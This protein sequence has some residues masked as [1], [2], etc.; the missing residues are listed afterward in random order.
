M[1]GVIDKSLVLN[2]STVKS[3]IVYNTN[4]PEK[5]STVPDSNNIKDCKPELIEI[6]LD[7]PKEA[8]SRLKVQ[9][10]YKQDRIPV[11][12]ASHVNSLPR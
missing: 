10:V 2:P 3:S 8:F 6:Y 9:D 12:S 5:P 11:K 4:S 1:K 7:Y